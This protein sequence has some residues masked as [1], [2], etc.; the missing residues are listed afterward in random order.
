MPLAMHGA[1]PRSTPRFVGD[2]PTVPYPEMYVGW[3]PL[4]ETV[5]VPPA[6]FVTLTPP[7][8][9]AA[10]YKPGVIGVPKRNANVVGLVDRLIVVAPK[11]MNGSL[12]NTLRNCTEPAPSCN[13]GVSTVQTRPPGDATM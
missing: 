11:L 10:L 12:S 7:V 6:P 3:I 5:V 2:K 13:M 9:V 4:V 1:V 8:L